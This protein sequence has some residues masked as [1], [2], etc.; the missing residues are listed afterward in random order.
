MKGFSLPVVL[1]VVSLG[2]ALAAGSAF[3]TRQHAIGSRTTSAAAAVEGAAE[4]WLA[5]SVTAADQASLAIPVGSTVEMGTGSTGGIR[6][7]RWM[8]R[9]DTSVYWFV[10]EAR[11]TA[12][13]LLWRRLGVITHVRDSVL[14]L[15]PGRAFGDLH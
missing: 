11:T 7:S 13:P 8:T 6:A 1:F 2:G 3:V 5:G 12:K 14:G 9:V 4:D 10:V 15:V